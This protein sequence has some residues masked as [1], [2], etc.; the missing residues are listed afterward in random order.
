LYRFCKALINA[1]IAFGSPKKTRN[2][3]VGLKVRGS[4][5]LFFK[6]FGMWIAYSFCASSSYFLHL[7]N[8]KRY[9]RLPFCASIAMNIVKEKQKE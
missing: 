1:R 3:Y 2:E 7:W 8:S 6:H 5:K 9:S 4:S